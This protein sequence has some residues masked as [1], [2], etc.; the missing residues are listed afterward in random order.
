MAELEQAFWYTIKNSAGVA[1]LVSTRV[2]PNNA[3]QGATIPYVTFVRISGPRTY[4]FGGA[5]GLAHVR[6][7]VDCYAADTVTTSGYANVK[8]LATAVRGALEAQTG[9]LGDTG[10][11]VNV[12]M[13]HLENDQDGTPP[14][15]TPGAATGIHRVIQDWDIWHFE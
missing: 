15:L 8:A 10:K 9:S 11:K 1:A 7:Q 13:M 5:T 3:P 2:Y 14:D 12:R 6:M 4:H